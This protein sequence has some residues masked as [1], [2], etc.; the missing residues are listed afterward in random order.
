MLC[1]LTAV[2]Q[3]AVDAER[4]LKMML[5][6]EKSNFVR[7]NFKE[8]PEVVLMSALYELSR[9]VSYIK[10]ISQRLHISISIHMQHE[11]MYKTKAMEKVF[12]V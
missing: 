9:F 4:H 12:C 11:A 2:L 5:S 1:G 6:Y 3:A 8:K 10:R 7:S